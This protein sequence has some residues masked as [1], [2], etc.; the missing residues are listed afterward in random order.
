MN[1]FQMIEFLVNNPKYVWAAV[2]FLAAIT[3]VFSLLRAHFSKEYKF[4]LITMLFFTSDGKQS[5]SKM[6]INAAFLITAWAFVFLTMTEK[7]TEWYVIAF[8]GSWVTDRIF[9]RSNENK[10]KDESKP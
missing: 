4:D 3:I 6:R 1:A 10:N 9:A 8:L 7:L 5:D 2:S